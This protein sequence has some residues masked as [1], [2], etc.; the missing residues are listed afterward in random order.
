MALTKTT[1]DVR[2]EV[3]GPYKAVQVR[4]DTVIKDNGDEISR[5]GHR[6]VI[7]PCI[8]NGDT[9]SNTVITGESSEIQAVCNAVW[10]DAIRTAYKDM[11]DARD[12]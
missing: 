7:Q 6:R 10:T 5:K 11:V 3:V 2:I 12:S 1:E 8:K 4:T 9:W